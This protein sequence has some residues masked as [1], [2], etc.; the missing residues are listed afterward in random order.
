MRII[1][2]KSAMFAAATTFAFAASASIEF[3]SGG[4]ELRLA[5]ANGAV[6][7]LVAPDGYERVVAA[8]EAFTLQLLDGKG[9]PTRLKSSDFV[10]E[11]YNHEEHVERVEK[12]LHDLPVLH[13][14]TITWR[15]QN[16]LLVRM[17]ITAADGEFRFKPS[18]EGIPDGML[19]EWFDGP[20]VCISP[21]FPSRRAHGQA[22]HQMRVSPCDCGVRRLAERL[23]CGSLSFA[24][25][26][27][28]MLYY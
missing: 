12:S 14:S 16:G 5:D 13:G 23:P 19:L 18:I 9:E 1:G 4:A 25:S 22:V 2:L 27:T 24:K 10:F 7:S 21:V 28:K 6:E 3:K 8:N 11:G 20:Q 26:E 17:E 15:H